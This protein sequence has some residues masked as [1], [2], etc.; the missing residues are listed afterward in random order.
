MKLVILAAGSGT[1]LRPYTDNLP[2]CMVPVSGRPLID[3]LVD[4]AIAAGIDDIVIVRGYQAEQLVVSGARS[5]AKISFVLNPD[6]ASTNMIYSLWTARDEI[7]DP[8]IISYADILYE[9]DVLRALI[10][11]PDEISVVVDKDWK[12]YWEW[13][14][15][16][17]LSDAESLRLDDSG[18]IASIGQKANNIDDIEGQYIG[19]MKF[20][21]NGV[22][23]LSAKLNELGQ[24]NSQVPREFRQMYM[25]DLLQVMIDAGSNIRPLWINGRW[26]EIDSIKDLKIAEACINAESAKTGNDL[27]IERNNAAGR[28]A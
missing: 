26:V 21:G 28:T 23:T 19:L 16:D 1:R 14:F 6:Y 18:N 22:R 12:S 15:E 13:R 17:P 10:A 24:V 3:K 27:K 2:K 7:A 11:A 5:P 8:V 25:T 20:T 9:T 4:T